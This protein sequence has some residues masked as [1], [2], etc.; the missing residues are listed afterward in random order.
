MLTLTWNHTRSGRPM[1]IQAKNFADIWLRVSRIRY[2]Y[3][4]Y[5][6]FLNGKPI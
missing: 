6:M 4:N 5:P 3:P 1:K 2:V